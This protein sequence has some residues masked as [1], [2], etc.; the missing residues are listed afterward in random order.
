MCELKISVTKLSN[1]LCVNIISELF[2]LKEQYGENQV[3]EILQRQWTKLFSPQLVH[4]I[5]S[6]TLVANFSLRITPYAHYDGFQPQT[7]YGIALDCY[8]KHFP[9]ARER[10]NKFQK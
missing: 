7:L 2:Y 6:E 9:E 1:R 10:M 4:L 5:E 3:A 8:K